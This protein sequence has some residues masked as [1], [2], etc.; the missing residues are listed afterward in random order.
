MSYEKKIVDFFRNNSNLTIMR[1]IENLDLSNVSS[2]DKLIR[3]YPQYPI[4]ELITLSKIRKRTASKTSDAYKYLYS[5]KSGQQA[6]SDSL[7]KYHGEK[8]R[9]FLVIADLCCGAGMDLVSIAPG[10]ELCFA[11]D[12]DENT[13]LTAEYNCDQAGFNNVSFV[14]SGAELFDEDVQAVFIDPDRRIGQRRSISLEGMS[15]DWDCVLR[16]IKKYENVAVKMSPALDYRSLKIEV[17][18]T[19]EFIS[20]HNELKEIL[21]CTGVLAENGIRRK[22]VVLPENYIL[23]SQSLNSE[24]QIQLS[25]LKEFVFEPDSAIIR[26]GLV[27]DY[28]ELNKLFFLDEHI[29]L[30]TTN[31]RTELSG[32]FYSVIDSFSYNLKKLQKYIR[33]NRIGSASIKTRGFSDTVENFRK[34]I[35][36]RGENSCVIFIIRNAKK[37]EIIIT[38]ESD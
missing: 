23:G 12:T 11:V 28:A 21:L 15:P 25:T 36:F 33:E 29:A 6:S 1:E 27:S 3:L 37:H 16:L 32:R 35:T 31:E 20:V 7:C 38:E 13:L 14:N 30:L 10:K 18:H 34:K 5:D 2:I 9:D 19:F 24:T 4:R 17:P 22:A 8:F 26:A